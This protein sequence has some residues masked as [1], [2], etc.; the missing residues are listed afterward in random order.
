[1]SVGGGLRSG[2][3]GVGLEPG[4]DMAPFRAG[5]LNEE[6]VASRPRSGSSAIS[7]DCRA[8]SILAAAYESRVRI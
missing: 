5:E 8:F 3:V 1:V 6:R 2:G 7:R 4:D